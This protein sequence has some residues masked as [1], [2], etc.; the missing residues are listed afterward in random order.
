[1]RAA[2]LH[3]GLRRSTGES[4]L[5]RS[6]KLR[7][8]H[9]KHKHRGTVHQLHRQLAHLCHASSESGSDEYW[10]DRAAAEFGMADS[11]SNQRYDWNY[12][13]SVPG[14]GHDSA[15]FAR[16]TTGGFGAKRPHGNWHVG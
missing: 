15:K 12:R 13:D 9:S 8:N 7:T 5:F 10:H 16:S 4:V 2:V 11:V 1:M 3:G 14:V 6:D